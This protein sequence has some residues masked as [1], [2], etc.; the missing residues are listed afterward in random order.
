ME[1]KRFIC[2][3]KNLYYFPQRKFIMMEC[4]SSNNT[5][6]YNVRK[7]FIPRSKIIIFDFL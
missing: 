3:L 7:R 1:C 2:T 5:F 6:S 4:M